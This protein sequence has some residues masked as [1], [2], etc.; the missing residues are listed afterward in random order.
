MMPGKEVS[1]PN[2]NPNPNLTDL[3]NHKSETTLQFMV[4]PRAD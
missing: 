1:D 3:Y 4:V 2:P